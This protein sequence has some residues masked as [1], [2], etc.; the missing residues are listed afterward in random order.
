MK[1]AVM[2][3][4]AAAVFMVS[5]SVGLAGGPPQG[6]GGE[7]PGLDRVRV[8]VQL[9]DRAQASAVLEG[10]GNAASD[11]VE[12]SHLPYLILELPRQA[13]AGLQRSPH[14]VSVQ[15][16]VAEPPALSSTLP[17]INGD[18]VHAAGLTGAGTTVV[19]LDTGIDD[20]HDFFGENGSRIVAERCFSTPQHDGE[21][22]LCPNGETSDTDADIDGAY[23]LDGEENLCD[24]GTHVAGIAAGS[25]ASDP[26]NADGDG[27]APEASIIAIQVFTRFENYCG[28]P[29]VL[30]Y[31]SDQL[32]G[33]DEVLALSEDHP[34][35]NIVSANMSLGGG[36]YNYACDMDSRAGAINALLGAGVATT[37]S[38]G[39]N[40]FPWSVSAP[41]CISSAVTVGSTED[42]DTIAAYSNRGALLDIF[43]PGSDVTS[44]EEAGTYGIKSGTSMAAPHV[45]GALAVMREAYPSRPI[46]ELVDL[47]ISTGVPITYDSYAPPS[48]PISVTTP[49]LDLLAAMPDDDGDGVLDNV[50]NCPAVPN[51]DQADIDGDGIGNACD[52]DNDNDGIDDDEDRCAG[53]VL[54]D[55]D[56]PDELKKNRYYADVDGV[57]V[58]AEGNEAGFDVADTG[59]CSATQI[60]EAAGLG[61]GHQRFGLTASALIAWTASLT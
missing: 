13:I 31:T 24:H 27:V 19:V 53:T 29:C 47:L 59:G 50:D 1:R 51:P 9:D 46:Q 22:S 26:D 28:A 15:E 36:Q 12:L 16:D 4:V 48:G 3:V 18:D 35:W 41:G 44:S 14:V 56:R 40:G 10:L 45:A 57:F 7:P 21:S 8:I 5:G 52:T 17:V 32:R 55:A 11:V 34:E 61:I 20:D 60:I 49:R 2:A 37:I 58:D 43:A 33:L 25:F 38:S 23:C 39:N 42:D 30:S 54:G 6:A